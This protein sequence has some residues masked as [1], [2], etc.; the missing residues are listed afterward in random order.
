M[1]VKRKF[2]QTENAAAAASKQHTKTIF[3]DLFKNLPDQV[4]ASNPVG[5][6]NNKLACAWKPDSGV[7]LRV[8]T[9][10]AMSPSE[11]SAYTQTNF[12]YHGLIVAG[13]FSTKLAVARHCFIKRLIV[14]TSKIKRYWCTGEIHWESLF[15]QKT[16]R[17]RIYREH[18]S[19]RKKFK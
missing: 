16:G 14:S 13:W 17:F 19:I 11:Q 8:L 10:F 9:P 15:K 12:Q 7:V 5:G 2:L 3:L 1:C 18:H 4:S 6:R